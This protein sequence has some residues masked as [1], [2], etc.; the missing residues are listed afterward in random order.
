MSK[1]NFKI[2]LISSIVSASV[3][4]TSLSW[5]ASLDIA[6]KPL[7]ISASEAPLVMMVMGRDHKLYYEAYNDASDLNNDGNLDTTYKPNEMDYFGYFNSSLCYDYNQDEERFEP[8]ATT[9][10]KNRNGIEYKKTCDNNKWSGDFLNYLTTSRIDALRKVL[11]GGYRSVDEYELT[12]LRRSYIPQDAHSWGKEYTSENHD[13]YHIND[14]SPL[15]T[16]PAN[17]KHLFANT[18]LID[19]TRSARRDTL[20][21]TPVEPAIGGSVSLP[22]LRVVPSTDIRI[23]EWVSK[24][25]PVADTDTSVKDP[26]KPY[27]RNGRLAGYHNK[28]FGQQG[29]TVITGP[30]ANNIYDFAVQVKVC[31]KAFPSEDCKIYAGNRKDED[32]NL[33]SVY[34]PVGVLQEYGENEKMRFGLFSGSYNKNTS[35]GVLRKAIR[36]FKDEVDLSTGIFTN[37]NGIVSTIDKFRVFGLGGAR[38]YYTKEDNGYRC[39]E[40]KTIYRKDH[41]GNYIKDIN[42]RK[43]IEEYNYYGDF[44]NTYNNELRPLQDGKCVD[45]GNPIAE[46][47]YEV[48]RY[49]SN[50]GNPSPAFTFNNNGSIDEALG[51]NIALWN[52]PYKTAGNRAGYNVCAKPVQLV[53]SDINPSYDSDQIP[54]SIFSNNIVTATNDLIGFNVNALAQDIWDKERENLPSSNVF[55]GQS[56]LRN[57]ADES[58]DPLDLTIEEGNKKPVVHYNGAPTAKPISSFGNIRGLAPEDPNRQG[59]YLSAA[60][61]LYGR[62]NKIS[63]G[64]YMIQEGVDGPNNLENTG[65]EMLTYSVALASPLPKIKIPVGGSTVT[66]VPFAKTANGTFGEHKPTNQIVDFYVEE[67]N[68]D[69]NSGSF[70][71]NFEDVEQGNDHD[72][73]AIVRYEYQVLGGNRVEI[74]LRSEYAG[75]GAQQH[76]GYVITGTTKDGIY[77]EVRDKDTPYRSAQN[78]GDYAL[79]TPPSKWADGTVTGK[80]AWHEYLDGSGTEGSQKLPYETSRIFTAGGNNGNAVQLE[81]PLWYAAKWGGFI[82]EPE[83]KNNILDQQSEWDS[84]G[85]NT[86]D[87]YFLVTNASKLKDQLR[88]AFHKISQSTGSASGVSA[89][90]TALK[91]DTLVY[92]AKFDSKSWTGEI[93]ASKFND[94][95]NGFIEVWNASEKIDTQSY[96][97][98]REIL[99]FNPSFGLKG[100]GAEFS[101]DSISA[102]Q[103]I[104]LTNTAPDAVADKN[105]WAKNLIDYIR[106]RK[107][108]PNFRR[109]TSVLGDIANSTPQYSGKPP[110][111]YPTYWDSSTPEG[112]PGSETYSQFTR[113]KKNRTPILAV[114]ANDGMLHILKADS[115]ASGGK[116][117]LAY[118]PSKV[119]K[120]LHKLADNQYTSTDSH[121]YFVNGTPTIASAFYDSKWHTILVGTLG[122]GG[123]GLFALDITDPTR[124]NEANAGNIALWEFNDDT[125]EQSSD[126][127]Y[128]FS[129]VEI[130]RYNNGHW[131]AVFGN[132]YNSTENDGN[133]GSGNAVLYILDIKTGDVL[134]KIDTNVGPAQ[135]PQGLYRPNGLSSPIGADIDGDFIVDYVFAGDLYGNLWAFDVSST[136]KNSWSVLGGEP[137]FKATRNG[138]LS[139]ITV[140][141]NLTR[142][143]NTNKKSDLMIFFGT[144]KYFEKGDK[145]IENNS[146]QTFYGL[147]FDPTDPKII[148]SN[149]STLLQQK[150]IFERNNLRYRTNHKICWDK[151]CEGKTTP[152]KGHDGWYM[153]LV[154]TGGGLSDDNELV[155]GANTDNLGERVTTQGVLYAT[156][157]YFN[158]MLPSESVC[159]IGGSGWKMALNQENGGYIKDQPAYD[160][161]G[162]GSF[163]GKDALNG[164]MP[165]GSKLDGIGSSPNFMGGKTTTRKSNDD[166]DI[167]DVPPFMGQEGRKSWKQLKTQ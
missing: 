3:L 74:T 142:R 160:Y 114:G 105:E 53:I 156:S 40:D 27:Y 69:D 165:G 137:I 146:T 20:R 130:G 102:V 157:V 124:F 39:K 167:D 88:K 37:I 64:R 8:V 71:I 118:V 84:D 127:G 90:S 46:M 7:F 65:E 49:F 52:Q 68:K 161:N 103:R 126:L 98:G 153:D 91:S 133:V 97:L 131:A 23:W 24:E 54:S 164:H 28:T 107:N 96:D 4:Q 111:Y 2:T 50:T 121:T 51:L 112:K 43:I 14:Y 33:V 119:Y 136:D 75:G 115:S 138:N 66:L 77:L 117:L 34:K 93:T 100:R 150:I 141:P 148:P 144:G 108:L 106:G 95:K 163:D 62:S 85:D 67:I 80:R 73:D 72:M 58:T 123:Q 10:T 45:W 162:D 139:P 48:V 16:P 132:G 26:N 57:A 56:A 1:I 129:N 120:N 104:L 159:G 78:A 76:I 94:T 47:M 19:Y 143:P 122:A 151:P 42:G 99:T 116:E 15:P 41:N 29:G 140:K 60:V 6:N 83:E 63:S 61:A 22:L 18:S 70:R 149:R 9:V 25:R 125:N 155:A 147:R 113:D 145:N 158:T 21:L 44:F 110:Q 31:D 35:G 152:A 36:N 86:P 166:E 92:S 12:V 89:N 81:N 17:T 79:N 87:S 13:G 38:D 128:T 135:D 101:W 109:R 5:G 134:K 32:D 11:Y 154:D 55:I 59:S 30:T 82:E